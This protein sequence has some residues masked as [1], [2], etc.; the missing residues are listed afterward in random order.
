MWVAT[1]QVFWCPPSEVL[2][3]F[4]SPIIGSIRTQQ[5]A[6]IQDSGDYYSAL[7]DRLQEMVENSG[8]PEYWLQDANE[9]LYKKSLSPIPDLITDVNEAKHLIYSNPALQDRLV[10]CFNFD[11]FPITITKNDPIA[12]E[13]Y[14]ETDLEGWLSTLTDYRY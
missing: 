1:D 10:Y 13:A 5:G 14:V 2:P 3:E 11:C 4:L 7:G 9:W 6:V 12:E 8:D